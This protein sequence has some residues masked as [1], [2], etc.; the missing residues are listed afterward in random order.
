MN[1][2]RVERIAGVERVTDRASNLANEA[3]MHC[4]QRLD[5]Q[6]QR[7][8]L[9]TNYL[10]EYAETIGFSPGGQARV[11]ALQNYR[12]FM[13]RIE[14]TIEQQRLVV[15]EVEEELVTRQ[16]EAQ[17][18]N[19]RHRAVEKLHGR[20]ENRLAHEESRQEQRMMDGHAGVQGRYFSGE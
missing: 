7:L 8:D 10:S 6:R 12:A 5:E 14:Q 2:K 16:Q 15:A 18:A 19:T 13:A 20:F 4:Q 17:E 9:L 11:F 1:R 3:V